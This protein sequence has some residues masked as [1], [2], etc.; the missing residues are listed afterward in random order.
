MQDDH[1][2]IIIETDK[3]GVIVIM[4]TAFYREKTLEML[5]NDSFYKTSNDTCSKTTFK[6]IKNLIKLAKDISRHEI[7]YLLEFDFKSSNFYGLPKIHKSSLIKSKCGETQS[8]IL[9]LKDPIDLQFRPIVAGPVC[10]TLRLS[11]LINIL[12]KPFIKCVKNFVRD[13]RHFL[14]F[15]PNNV[16]EKAIIVSFDVTSLY[17][18]ISHELGLEAIKFWLEKHPNLIHKR[19]SKEFILEGIKVILEN[20]KS[21]RKAIYTIRKCK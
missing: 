3:G 20:E 1:T 9:E 18:D 15:I 6:K 11:N 16:S 21:R 10:E 12:L 4:N 8:G 14:S 17:I 19:F 5:A 13:D 2:K 7:A